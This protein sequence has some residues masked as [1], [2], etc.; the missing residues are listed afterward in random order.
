[1]PEIVLHQRS[2]LEHLNVPGRCGALDGE[3][4][5][6]LSLRGGVALA[7][8]I[9]RK[10]RQDELAQRVQSVFGFAL[11]A[12]PRRNA[13]G[14]IAFSWTG[15]DQWLAM[16]E[17]LASQAFERRLRDE[18]SGL[19]SVCEQSDGRTLIRFGGARARDALAKGVIIDLHPRAFGPG[20][21]AVTGFAH[22]PVHF[23]QIDSAP[24]YDFTVFRSLAADFWR[25][26]VDAG[27]EFGVMIE[28]SG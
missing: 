6:T 26:L 17:G 22:I 18:L 11:P 13:A 12:S 1:V 2:G 4:G 3:A 5:V 15:P 9:A 23:W 7:S 16:A 20:D 8:V 19:A 21:A 10:G 24:T 27:S 28:A 25:G 14:S